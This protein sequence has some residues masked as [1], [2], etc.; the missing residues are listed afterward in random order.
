[1]FTS[2]CNTYRPSCVRALI[3]RNFQ[4]SKDRNIQVS[5]DISTG[6]TGSEHEAL[7][8]LRFQRRIIRDYEFLHIVRWYLRVV[9][10]RIGLHAATNG[11]VP[12]EEGMRKI[13]VFTRLL[14]RIE[15]LHSRV[16]VYVLAKITLRPI[17]NHGAHKQEVNQQFVSLP[18]S[19][20]IRIQEICGYVPQRSRAWKTDLA[21]HCNANPGSRIP[22]PERA[23]DQ[24]QQIP[25]DTSD[26]HQQNVRVIPSIDIQ[27]QDPKFS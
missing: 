11:L 19:C 25:T 3:P 17:S 20:A 23:T 14:P 2:E 27:G 1:M 10:W 13:V 5:K 21:Y 7:E 26:L 9:R 8:S 22:A 24:L 12:P 15:I 18:R 4:V 16:R 6:P